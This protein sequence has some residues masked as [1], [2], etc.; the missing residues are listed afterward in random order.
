DMC[1]SNNPMT[2]NSSFQGHLEKWIPEELQY[3][4]QFWVA[5][6]QEIPRRNGDNCT[7]AAGVKNFLF[8][9]VLH[10]VEAMVLLGAQDDIVHIVQSVIEWFGVCEFLILFHSS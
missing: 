2:P 9:H 7:I 10:W 8:Q 5:H 1:Q 4:C 6:L 3:A